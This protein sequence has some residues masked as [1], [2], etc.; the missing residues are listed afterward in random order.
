SNTTATLIADITSGIVTVKLGSTFAEKSE[1]YEK[2]TIKAMGANGSPS[3]YDM[4][5]YTK[6]A[7]SFG[8]TATADGKGG[9]IILSA[10]SNWSINGNEQT[11]RT[12]PTVSGS[13]EVYGANDAKVYS[14]NLDTEA[15]LNEA[16]KLIGKNRY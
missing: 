11:E 10:S 5:A 2:D 3:E 4:N 15:K 14:E 9:K 8:L 12:D 7:Y 13:L 6:E 16:L 1:A